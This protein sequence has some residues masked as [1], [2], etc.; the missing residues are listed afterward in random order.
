[1]SILQC[2]TLISSTTLHSV[3]SKPL[4]LKKTKAGHEHLRMVRTD[5]LL[6][7]LDKKYWFYIW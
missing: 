4:V 6:S 3:F 2:Y 5:N 7:N 1:M